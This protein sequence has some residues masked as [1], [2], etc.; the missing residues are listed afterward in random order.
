MKLK[1]WDID[2]FI[3]VETSQ[4]IVDTMSRYVT[5]SGSNVTGELT[6]HGFGCMISLF[7]GTGVHMQRTL[8]EE[9]L[10]CDLAWK[11]GRLWGDLLQKLSEH[12][13]V[14]LRKSLGPD[15][16]VWATVERLN[17]MVKADPQAMHALV[18]HRVPCDEKIVT[19][20][21]AVPTQGSLLSLGMLGVINGLMPEGYKIVA[22]FDDK[23]EKLIDFYA[24]GT[25]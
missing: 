10:R 17:A 21:P 24:E 18:E 19:D 3:P 7:H 23:T 20:S 16:L 15:P 14:E 22:R 1:R 2:P 9:D 13:L 5:E 6:K 12:Q 11:M 4:L 8:S 25:K